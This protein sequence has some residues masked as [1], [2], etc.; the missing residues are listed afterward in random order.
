M[1]KTQNFTVMYVI[2]FITYREFETV[3]KDNFQLVITLLSDQPR[4]ATVTTYYIV[5]SE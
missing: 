5:I 2:Y 4:L 1:F 3:F